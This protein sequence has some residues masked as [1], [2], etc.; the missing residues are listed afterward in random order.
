MVLASITVACCIAVAAAVVW[1][2]RHPD[3]PVWPPAEFDWRARI[4]TWSVTVIAIG[5]AYMAGRT[6]WNAWDW[7]DWIRWYVGFPLAFVASSASSWAI[8]KLGLDQSMGA[9]RG[10]VT[11]GVFARTRNPTYVANL[12]LCLGWA[13][14]AA[15]WPAAIAA[16]ALAALYVFAVPFEEKWLART[17]GEAY[18][19]Y[20]DATPRWF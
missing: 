7:P 3:R 1:S 15:S 19:R 6:S 10:L 11:D 2:A 16:G 4:A 8:V 14:L 13:L 18:G 9:D 17:Y 20:R 5:A 12:V